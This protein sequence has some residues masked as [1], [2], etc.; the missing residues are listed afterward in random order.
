ML[1]S[2]LTSLQGHLE[3]VRLLM[4][5]AMINV[6]DKSGWTPLHRAAARGHTE[7][8]RFLLEQDADIDAVNSSGDTPL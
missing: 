3:V 2:Q 7:V 5:G 6:R 8:V 1:G 4:R